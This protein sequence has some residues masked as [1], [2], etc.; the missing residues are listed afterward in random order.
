MIWVRIAQ[1]IKKEKEYENEKKLRE[2]D[3]LKFRLLYVMLADIRCIAL[4]QD[5]YSRVIAA[6]DTK[7]RRIDLL[8][9][10][11]LPSH[12]DRKEQEQKEYEERR[13]RMTEEERQEEDVR[14]F[15]EGK[16]YKPG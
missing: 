3:A 5:T 6:K 10:T 13:S 15:L 16:T 4:D 1:N 14:C 11:L 8:D 12:T 9:I 2:A 7:K